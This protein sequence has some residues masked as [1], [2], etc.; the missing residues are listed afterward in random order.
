MSIKVFAEE[1]SKEI[2]SY[3]EAITAAGRPMLEAEAIK[4]GF[5]QA[6]IDRE[7]DYPTGL[8]LKGNIGVAIPHG[9]SKLV[10]ESSISFVRLVRPIEFG[11]M[12]DASQSVSVQFVFN[13]A[14]SA[15]SQHLKALQKLMK[16]FQEPDFLYNIGALPEGELQEYLSDALNS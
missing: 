6:C 10:N 9:N 7:V 11:L 5:S 16:L 3:Q 15:G 14:L 4:S 12:E 2:N 13:L 1:G 8:K